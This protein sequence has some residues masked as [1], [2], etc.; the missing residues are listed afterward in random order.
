MLLFKLSLQLLPEPQYRWKTLQETRVNSEYLG[1]WT[2][3][4]HNIYNRFRRRFSDQPQTPLMR[5]RYNL[6]LG[7]ALNADFLR[8]AWMHHILHKE[9]SLFHLTVG[10]FILNCSWHVPIFDIEE[11]IHKNTEI[12][13]L[14][15]DNLKKVS[16]VQQEE[17]VL[18]DVIHSEQFNAISTQGDDARLNVSK[19]KCFLGPHV[20]AALLVTF[21]CKLS[22]WA[23][24]ALRP[25]RFKRFSLLRL[26]TCSPLHR[27]QTIFSSIQIQKILYWCSKWTFSGKY[28]Y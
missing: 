9:A 13:V 4:Y 18:P 6:Q 17:S 7:A 15:S 10:S 2:A 28:S 14:Y 23:P 3:P 5:K 25:S 26:V 21:C 8:G 19:A 16:L 27:S 1:A 20:S 11:K 22:I 12:T 24:V